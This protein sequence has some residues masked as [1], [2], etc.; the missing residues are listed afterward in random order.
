MH[1]VC[2]CLLILFVAPLS[3]Q[4][5][6]PKVVFPAAAPAPSSVIAMATD[7]VFVVRANVKCVVVTSP[8]SI[9]SVT[10]DTGPVKMRAKFTDGAGKYETKAFAE[11]FVWFVE[12]VAE[13]RAELILVTETGEIVRKTIQVG[14]GPGP[15]PPDPPDPPPD[16]EPADPLFPALKVAYLTDADADK[17]HK[18]ELLAALWKSS[19]SDLKIGVKATAVIA[20]MHAA[21][22]RDDMVGKGGLA[23]VRKTLTTEIDRTVVI[24]ESTVIDAALQA[25]LT[26]IFNRFSALLKALK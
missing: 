7:Q 12:P 21:A 10:A 23:N 4:E 18:V 13:G 1:R 2:A 25:R 11:K 22:D 14:K 6:A 26:V 5:P 8:E 19:I 20:L 16:V 17:K 3:A 15:K 9:V 24:R